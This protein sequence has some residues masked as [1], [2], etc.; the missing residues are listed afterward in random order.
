VVAG[1]KVSGSVI[2][3]PL[4]AG[5]LRVIGARYDLDDGKVEFYDA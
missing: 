2:Q 4:A 5:K 3:D 1:L